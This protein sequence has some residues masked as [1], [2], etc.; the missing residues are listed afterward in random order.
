MAIVQEISITTTIFWS[1]D[2]LFSISLSHS[3]CGGTISIK[4]IVVNNELESPE[5]SLHGV[6][7]GGKNRISEKHRKPRG[8]LNAFGWWCDK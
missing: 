4:W 7:N 1:L 3:K 6:E 2:I 8:S 5:R